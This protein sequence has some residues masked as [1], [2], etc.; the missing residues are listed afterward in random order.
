MDRKVQAGKIAMSLN[1][2][3]KNLQGCLADPNI[4][5][6]PAFTMK[7]PEASLKENQDNFQECDVKKGEEKPAPISV[8]LAAVA[9]MCKKATICSK[10]V[11]DVIAVIANQRSRV[12]SFT[13]H[14]S[15]HGR[16][17]TPNVHWSPKVHR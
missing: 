13:I 1:Q 8:D 4:L 5:H 12:V 3:I 15:M 10:D 7:F 11:L 14:M 9:E 17:F 16:C 6:V 2:S